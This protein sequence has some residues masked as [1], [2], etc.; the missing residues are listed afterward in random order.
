MFNYLFQHFKYMIYKITFST[1]VD[2]ANKMVWSAMPWTAT[3]SESLL[4][5][6]DLA[7]YSFFTYGSTSLFIYFT[8]FSSATGTVNFRYKS[9]VTWTTLLGSAIYGDYI[10]ATT[11]SP[12]SMVLYSI[13]LV[14]FQNF[15]PSFVCKN[16]NFYSLTQRL[17][18]V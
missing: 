4:S 13:Q 7:I 5:S 1:S 10:I 14:P 18:Q 6:G 9:N 12:T 17:I 3:Y 16:R 8:S 15:Y 11:Q 2:W